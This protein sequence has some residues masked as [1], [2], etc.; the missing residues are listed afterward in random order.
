MKNTFKK[1]TVRGSS[2][3]IRQEVSFL[4]TVPSITTYHQSSYSK[5]P[6]CYCGGCFR[7]K[8][9]TDMLNDRHLWNCSI[10]S[11]V[12]EEKVFFLGPPVYKISIF[13]WT[14]LVVNSFIIYYNLYILF[15]ESWICIPFSNDGFYIFLEY[16]EIS[17]YC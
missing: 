10:S 5:P 1:G 14:L 16:V 2:D 7:H 11:C 17:F 15:Y 3:P 9:E 4:V 13:S 12:I 6:I 8:F